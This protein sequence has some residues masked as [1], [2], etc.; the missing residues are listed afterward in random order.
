MGNK[1]RIQY[2]FF[3]LALLSGL[4]LN[5]QESKCETKGDE[6]HGEFNYEKAIDYYEHC[7][8]LTIDGKIN[9]AE[10]Y[11]YTN[12]L[13]KSGV[14]YQDLVTS[15]SANSQ[16]V[17]L[18]AQ[19]LKMRGKYEESD[20]WM[21]K[22]AALN[23]DDLR[24]KSFTDFPDY[25]KALSVNAG[26]WK[27]KTID[28]N[29]A[30]EDFSPAYYKNK[31]VFSSS[32]KKTKMIS[33]T[34]NGTKLPFIDLYVVDSVEGQ[35]SEKV[36]EFPAFFNDKFHDGPASFTKNG[37]LMFFTRNNYD[38]N[39]GEG[40]K[41]LQLFYSEYLDEKWSEPRG[42]VFNSPEYSTGH[43][44]VSED[45]K[46]IYFVSDMPGGQG[47]TDLYKIV[48]G[49]DSAWSKPFNMGKS[50][51]TEGNEMFPF[52]HESGILYFSSNGHVGLGGLD[53]FQTDLKGDT[54]IENLGFPINDRFDDFGLIMNST[55][56]NGYFSSNRE[57][58]LGFDD[59]YS[60]TYDKPADVSEVLVEVTKKPEE[61]I[62]PNDSVM[63]DSTH[64]DNLDKLNASRLNDA[65]E[66][67]LGRVNTEEEII[68]YEVQIGAYS[69]EIDVS[70]FQGLP[71]VHFK[72]R[73]G[74]YKYYTGGFGTR[75]DGEKLIE[76]AEAKG[77]EAPFLVVK[78][79]K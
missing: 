50:I 64:S 32:R 63:I 44:S 42:F 60:F 46:T 58:G 5:A 31:I 51:N 77:V 18:H 30:Q 57:G 41:K 45:G 52:F 20:R 16:Y 61:I 74:L 40:T 35:L 28:I 48:Y 72:L 66:A 6:L 65:S 15:D 29:S 47:G 55:Q 54:T 56:S 79:T 8:E 71:N 73:N 68:L 4:A 2:G 7:D 9:L 11:R 67:D 19:V 43:P 49:S 78:K 69:K 10:A 70:I 38:S 37:K 1:N 3:I 39:S 76:A 22:L 36:T 53:L 23:K 59:I 25:Y 34:W 62:S 14:I 24:G 13:D 33:K 12:Q 26:R 27:I 17:F 21:K 75:S